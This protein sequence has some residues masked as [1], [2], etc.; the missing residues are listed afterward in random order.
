LIV[1]AGEDGES[2]KI[3]GTCPSIQLVIRVV[4][5]REEAD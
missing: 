4:Y 1:T 2:G 5:R 3:G